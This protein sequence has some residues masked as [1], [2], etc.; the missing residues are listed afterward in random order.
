MKVDANEINRIVQAAA[1]VTRDDDEV[2]RD[3]AALAE[4]IGWHADNGVGGYGRVAVAVL[5]RWHDRLAAASD[6]LA[7]DPPHEEGTA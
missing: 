5:R 4:A 6:R 7:A 2:A 3:L 1:A